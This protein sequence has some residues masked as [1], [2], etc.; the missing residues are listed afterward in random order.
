MR[1]FLAALVVALLFGCQN[2]DPTS[3]TTTKSDFHKTFFEKE[4]P[5][6]NENE[7]I[8]KWKKEIVYHPDGHYSLP[9]EDN[10]QFWVDD[11]DEALHSYFHKIFDPEFPTFKDEKGEY[12]MARNGFR[13]I[14]LNEVSFSHSEGDICVGIAY[15][16]SVRLENE[17]AEH[18]AAKWIIFNSE[19]TQIDTLGGKWSGTYAGGY[20]LSDKGVWNNTNSGL[21]FRPYTDLYPSTEIPE[22]Y[23]MEVVLKNGR[24][25]LV[26]NNNPLDDVLLDFEE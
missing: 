4:R 3:I 2:S 19:M 8:E 25:Y 14:S 6:K 18:T 1:F 17:N 12:L 16:D 21:R 7:T 24:Y 9:S 10:F 23:Q 11:I 22:T 13:T 5:A 15:F 20:V 26:Y